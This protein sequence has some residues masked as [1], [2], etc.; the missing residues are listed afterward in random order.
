MKKYLWMSS[1][2]VVIS[3]LRVKENN[4]FFYLELTPVEKGSKSENNRVTSRESVPI[5]LKYMLAYYLFN[6]EK[7]TDLVAVY[8]YF[9]IKALLPIMHL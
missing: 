6:C 4:L 7:W 3:A 1:A 2:A 5:H 8:I 9:T